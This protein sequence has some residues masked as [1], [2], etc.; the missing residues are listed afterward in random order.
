MPKRNDNFIEL[1]SFKFYLLLQTLV[2]G[3]IMLYQLLWLVF[4]TTTMA[5]CF[6]YG[7]KNELQNSGTLYYRYNTFEKNYE[8]YG[9]RNEV[10]I[11]Q[12]SIEIKYLSFAPSFSRINSFENNWLGFII[13]YGLFLVITSLIFLIDNDTMPKNSY[14]YFTKKKPWINMIVK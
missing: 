10:P 5:D 6:V 1:S 13:A 14:F 4:G 7:H 3:S 11:S 12:E 8:D 2:V 9:T